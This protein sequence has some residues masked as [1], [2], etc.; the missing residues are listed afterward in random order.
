MLVLPGL[1]DAGIMD[2]SLFIRTNKA[3][4]LQVFDENT[5]SVVFLG[6]IDLEVLGDLFQ[7]EFLVG[8]TG[9]KC[10]QIFF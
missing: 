6:A 3:S 7:C 9:K 8:V 4:A 2:L 1:P 5:Q 10:E